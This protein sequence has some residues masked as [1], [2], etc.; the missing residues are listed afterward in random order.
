[1]H[2]V[3]AAHAGHMALDVEANVP[4][5]R[6]KKPQFTFL[7]LALLSATWLG[8]MVWTMHDFFGNQ[9]PSR[10]KEQTDFHGG[11][12]GSRYGVRS[13]A[14]CRRICEEHP[15]C[16]AFTYVTT[17]KA[18]WLKGDG[19][20]AETNPNAISGA[21][22][23]TL[24]AKRRAA[25]RDGEYFESEDKDY[26]MQREAEEADDE[27]EVDESRTDRYPKASYDEMSRR[28]R[29][30]EEGELGAAGA[31]FGV[32]REP[33]DGELEVYNDSTSFFGDVGVFTDVGAAS[34][35]EGLCLDDGRCVA[36][37]LDKLKA[38]CMLRLRN[39]STLRYGNDV[40]GARLS[41]GYMA[42]R[43]AKAD[44]GAAG[45]AR[46]RASYG[47]QEQERT[48]SEA[49]RTAVEGAG[50]G[51][52]GNG[53]SSEDTAG[54]VAATDGVG[55][56]SVGS[57]SAYRGEAWALPAEIEDLT[58]VF[59]NTDFVGADIGD[60]AGIDSVAS[61]QHVCA[62]A[63]PHGC[64]AWTLSKRH[65]ICYLK[66]A[67]YTLSPQNKSAALISGVAL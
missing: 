7:L 22:N 46:L 34:E 42:D 3:H 28:E 24:V 53:G 59:D 35:C 11:D 16:L 44:T 15:R 39:T 29:E 51:A 45:D 13:P 8:L 4:A 18:C 49:N 19:F 36:W 63:A 33:T 64:A 6:M 2:A 56:Y 25:R 62:S 57:Q 17:D 48:G 1:M 54:G 55:L 52:I 38:L 43:A 61:C 47:E 9:K 20:S 23:T 65:Q 14:A 58:T 26:D 32:Y 60:V 31:S 40:I 37:T 41:A 5:N 50:V 30:R 10:L 27:G 12:I 67:N 21:M 66:S